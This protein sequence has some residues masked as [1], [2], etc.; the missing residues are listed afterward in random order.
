MTS[1][2][3]ASLRIG[4]SIQTSSIYL[5]CKYQWISVVFYL[6]HTRRLIIRVK[7]LELWG[8]H[9]IRVWWVCLRFCHWNIQSSFQMASF[10]RYFFSNYSI[11]RYSSRCSS[12]CSTGYSTGYFSHTFEWHVVCLWVVSGVRTVPARLCGEKI[13]LNAV[14]PLNFRKVSKLYSH[15]RNSL[16]V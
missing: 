6:I 13:M 2:W 10:F 16:C 11:T 5:Q 15:F 8:A 9:I 1:E 14:V 12:R 7:F 3:C 4:I